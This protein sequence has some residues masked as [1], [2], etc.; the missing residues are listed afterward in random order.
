MT[1]IRQNFSLIAGDDT[2]VDYG[3]TPPPDPPFDI[4]QTVLNWTAYPQVRGVADKTMPV[5]SKTLAGGGIEIEDATSYAFVVHLASA[6]TLELDGNYY[7]EIVVVDPNNNNWRSTPTIGTLTVIDTTDP[8][9]VVAFKSMFPAMAQYDD[10]IL[11]TA[12]DEA[13]QFVDEDVWTPTDFVSATYYLAAHFVF[14]A[15]ISSSGGQ[16]ISSERIGQISVTYSVTSA[17][18]PKSGIGTGYSGLLNS[19]YGR[20]YLALLTRNSPGIAIV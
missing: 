2:D 3:I 5:V 12:L 19:D 9:N 14:T 8:I 20:M 13:G 16:T 11:Q 17:V 6:D 10:G 15:Q 4:S 7:Y 1:E 18:N